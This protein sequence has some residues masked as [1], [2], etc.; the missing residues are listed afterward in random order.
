MDAVERA[1]AIV[2]HAELIKKH[3]RR[4]AVALDAACNLRARFRRVGKH[5]L[6][7]FLHEIGNKSHALHARCV[8][9]VKAEAIRYQ[10]VRFVIAQELILKQRIVAVKVIH[11]AAQHR[12]KARINAC[13]NK[14]I[15]V[16]IHIKAAR[17]AACQ[18]F[19][20]RQAR[21][22]VKPVGAKACLLRPNL[23]AE[24]LIQ[25]HIVGKRAQKGHAGVRMRILKARN[26]QVAVK[27]Y[28]AL[29]LRHGFRCR[30]DMDYPR[31]VRPHLAPFYLRLRLKCQHAAVIKTYHSFILVYSQKF[32][33]PSLRTSF[34]RNSSMAV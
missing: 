22:D 32:F 25:R 29:K 12:A 8:F 23:L 27:V 19:H 18:V 5:R 33:P 16:K 14:R 34:A 30:A 13:L 31:A 28:L 11:I 9:R 2:I 20:Y 7:I 26:E 1:A 3:R 6:F 10:L 17:Y 15:V 24:P 21:H 4:Y